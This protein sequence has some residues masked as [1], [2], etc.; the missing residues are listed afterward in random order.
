MPLI[1]SAS[2]LSILVLSR[3]S[4]HTTAVKVDRQAQEITTFSPSRPTR[5]QLLSPFISIC[6]RAFSI[7]FHLKFL[8][9]AWSRR[10]VYIIR[11]CHK[12]INFG[13]LCFD[14]VFFYV[15]VSSIE[16][17]KIA[18]RWFDKNEAENNSVDRVSSFSNWY[19]LALEWNCIWCVC[20]WMQL[21]RM[22]IF[23]LFLFCYVCC[24]N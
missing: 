3:N 21:V 23:I 20:V 7:S 18:I 16:N 14:S 12:I 15:F 9:L 24:S 10:H 17:H 1:S 4:Q 13:A 5:D 11:P 19:Q 6:Y 8:A 22:K 2:P